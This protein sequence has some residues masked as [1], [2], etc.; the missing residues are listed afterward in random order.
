MKHKKKKTPFLDFYNRSMELER[1]ADSDP[2]GLCNSSI[3]KQK[4]FK[5]FIPTRSD[6]DELFEEEKSITFWATGLSLWHPNSVLQAAFTPLRQTI[7]LFC[8][9]INDEI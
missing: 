1:I 4:V 3:G 7:V 5:R 9:V 8:A 6:L 2:F